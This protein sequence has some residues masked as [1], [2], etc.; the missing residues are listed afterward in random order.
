[1]ATFEMEP[2]FQRDLKK[3][4]AQQRKTFE[5]VIRG[6]FVPDLNEGEFRPGLRVKRIKSLQGVTVVYEM[7]WSADGRA[8]WNY[9]EQLKPEHVHVVWRRIGTHDDLFPKGKSKG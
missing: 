9:G 1:M 3:L 8:T 2:S 5:T 7:T 4:T 6:Q